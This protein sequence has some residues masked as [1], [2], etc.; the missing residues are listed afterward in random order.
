MHSKQLPSFVDNSNLA[1]HYLTDSGVQAVCRVLSVVAH[2]RPDI[3]YS[4]LLFTLTA[5]LLHYIDEAACYTCVSCLVT[6]KHRYIAQTMI[7]HQAQALTI[8][9]LALKHAV[10]TMC[11]CQ[12]TDHK[13]A[14]FLILYNS[15]VSYGH[16]NIDCSLKTYRF[17][18]R[19]FSAAGLRLWND[20]PF[21]LR[22]LPMWVPG[23]R[24]D[25]LCLLAGCHKRRLNQA[26]LNLRGLI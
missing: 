20:L 14:S 22:W 2:E 8:S 16:P 3:T 24:I 9:E 15:L 7:S 10:C 11:C 6:S 21:R 1:Q 17:S 25:P 18:D 12:L 23:L 13:V 19:S 5:I 26:P 4:P